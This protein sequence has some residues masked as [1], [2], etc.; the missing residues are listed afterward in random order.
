MRKRGS[1]VVQLRRYFGA[2][3]LLGGLLFALEQHGLHAQS[4]MAPPPHSLITQTQEEVDAK[5]AGCVSCHVNEDE[6]TMHP[7]RTVRL[8]CTDCHGGDASAV[9]TPGTA[10]D[11]AAY[12]QVKA[13]AHVQPHD[14]VFARGLANAERAYTAWLRES[15]EYVRFANPGDLRVARQTCGSAGCHASEVRNVS[16]SMMTHGGDALGRGALQQRIAFR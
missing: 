8:G 16:T 4:Q 1:S 12:S 2:V 14:A 5:S 10:R 7:T 9:I 6:P 13:K 3:A 11:S 15:Y